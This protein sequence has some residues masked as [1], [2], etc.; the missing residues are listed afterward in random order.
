MVILQYHPKKEV[1]T[2]S[3]R[4][5]SMLLI[6]IMLVGLLPAYAQAEEAQPAVD[7]GKMTVEGTNGFGQLLSQDIAQ[8]QQS[9][10]SRPQSGYTL[11][12]LEIT[13]NTAT[14]T[15]NT[16]E[17]ATVM[18]AL[19]TEDGSQLLTSGK[20]TAVPEDT[21]VTVTI[22]GTVPQ[23]FMATAYLLDSYD[24]SPLCPSYDTPMYTKEMQDLLASTAEDYEADRVLQLEDSTQTNFA[25]YAPTTKVIEPKEGANL[26]TQADDATATYVIEKAD[27][28]ITS[29]QTGDV[30]AYA[31]SPVEI[32]I[33]KVASVTVTGTTVTI[34]GGE[35]EMEE[36]FSHVK[37]E[38]SSETQ[39]MT[40]DDSVASEG[41]T[42]QGMTSGPATRSAEGSTGIKPKAEFVIDEWE[43]KGESDE[44]DYAFS[45]KAS[46]LLELDTKFNYYVSTSKQYLEMTTAF[47]VS[48]V[49]TMEGSFANKIPLGKLSFMPVPG[50]SLGFEPA[51]ELRFSGKLEISLGFNQTVGFRYENG[52]E[53]E[54][55]STAP[56]I[57]AKLD[58]E[59]TIFFGIDLHP[60]ATVL[61]G[62]IKLELTALAGAEVKASMSNESTSLSD[63]EHHEC[64]NC[65]AMDVSLKLE[66]GVKLE[67]LKCDFLSVSVDIL[68]LTEPIGSMYYSLDLGRF[69][70]GTCPN[71]TYRV[72]VEVL[73]EDG[74]AVPE[75]P[76]RN[77][78]GKELGK[79]NENGVLVLFLSSGAHTLE[80]DI[81][82][83]QV[84]KSF[85][86]SDACS[87]K[88]S[89]NPKLTAVTV[90]QAAD[91]QQLLDRGTLVNSGTHGNLR[92]EYYNGGIVYI[93][94]EGEMSTTYSY[95][96]DY[97][98][99]W[100][101][102][103]VVG[104]GI[105]T[106][107]ENAFDNFGG[108]KQII[109]PSTLT[110][111]ENS[112]FAY[113]RQLTSITIPEGVTSIGSS[114]F[115]FADKLSQIT[116]PHSV[117]TIGSEAFSNCSALQLIEIGSG[118]REIGNSAFRQTTA[119]QGFR[120]S[121][122]NTYFMSDDRGVLYNKNQTLLIQAPGCLT[123]SYTPPDTVDT[124][125]AYAFYYCKNVTEI[126]LPEGVTELKNGAFSNC[127]ALTSI[128][129]PNSL[130]TV[131]GGVFSSSLNLSYHLH[132]N[133]KYLGNASNPYMILAKAAKTNIK[134]CLIHEDTRFIGPSAFDGCYQLGDV[135]IP[136][137]VETIC[138]D[139]FDGCFA[140]KNLVIPMNVKTIGDGAFYSC[141]NITSVD[142]GSGLVS[143]GS[144]AFYDADKLTHITIPDSVRYIGEEAFGS[145]YALT[146]YTLGSGISQIPD[147]MFHNTALT[148]VHFPNWITG[149][150][151]RA[152]S[153][154]D[155]LVSVTIPDHITQLGDSAFY[156]CNGLTQVTI[157][158]G[159]TSIGASAFNSCNALTEV[160]IGSSVT[161]I[162]SR[163]F[164]Q[165]ENLTTV[166]LGIGIKK[167][168]D[169]AFK[170]CSSLT[171]V[172]Y[173]GTEADWDQIEFIDQYLQTADSIHFSGAASRSGGTLSGAEM[174]NSIA[175]NSV[176]GGEY[177][178]ETVDSVTFKTANFKNLV[179]GEEY[180]LLN[181]LSMDTED[182]TA[183]DNLLF[184]GHGT[185]DENGTLSFRYIQRVNSKISY[186]MVCGASNKNLEDAQITFPEMQ[187][188]EAIQVPKPQVVYGGTVLTEG[189]DYVLVGDVDFTDAGVYTCYVRGIHSY[190]GLVEC[191]YTVKGAGVTLCG[192][193][194]TDASGDT[195]ITLLMD[196][197]EVASAAVSG[198]TG[199]YTLTDIA[200]GSYT[201]RV[202][203]LNHAS[204]DYPVT[205]EA[206]D[207]TLDVTLH[208]MGDV[209]GSGRVN[210]GDVAKLNAHVRAVTL[211]TDEYQLLC[212]NV[213][214]G[215]LNIGDVAALYS[216]VQGATMLY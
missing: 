135:F 176:F 171:D 83:E 160:T 141:W 129:L 205:V 216:H 170:F 185:A 22:E 114:A 21:Q 131:G 122:D 105:T 143:I 1:D 118:L 181:V 203:K 200:A 81:W 191:T 150:G 117:T 101:T 59:A 53:P 76:V 110:R 7:G 153:G 27:D 214:G 19:Y 188:T 75:T 139:A 106:I 66:L 67:F 63:K 11:T 44:F 73:E 68:K 14:V 151:E 51:L 13:G 144:K 189:A 77:G 30:L 115:Y 162:G 119:L 128:S 186:V 124:V 85:H 155:A 8:E 72:T 31:Y 169:L 136:Y 10:Q 5:I 123:G 112:A 28:Q 89:T 46:I 96:W 134:S 45:I 91:H 152:F 207:V 194:A 195:T 50:V 166:H 71:K 148:E 2:M 48:G 6:L 60:T 202:S 158:N 133:A 108:A 184:I 42:F 95:P 179:P 24:L 192:G 36:A 12:G 149:I 145:C 25:V 187:A 58:L 62:V 138:D 84:K 164:Y 52:K 206:E 17:T 55:L 198:K 56:K 109:L 127:S 142:L 69:D 29:L 104:E 3:K 178:S 161:S 168:N 41:V 100:A 183:A 99:K 93:Y 82:S 107:A 147:G 212:A 18:V 23:Y 79:T 64:K 199:A 167:I 57:T 9:T 154:C 177:G 211:I 38:S 180:V 98:G 190:T 204:R 140:L 20:A 146:S 157:G 210:I 132:D 130:Q 193:V 33:I 121:G 103:V 174:H 197:A 165:C 90:F 43:R 102:H 40:V 159:I 47:N 16:M 37:L 86:V 97:C 213:N 49:F 111:I 4:I 173:A 120:V 126:I 196:G 26:V 215:K 125:G 113:T 182:L 94:G 65:I 163:A 201:L 92:W 172:Y 137:Q 156:D 80:A 209:D 34:T 35:L 87:V 54:D 61:G 15:Y 116:I 74:D 175:Y 88:L 32:L 78:E 208:L 70:F 39:D